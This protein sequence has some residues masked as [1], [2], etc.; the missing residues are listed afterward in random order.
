VKEFRGVFDFVIASR[1]LAKQFRFSIRRLPQCADGY[2]GTHCNDRRKNNLSVTVLCCAFLLLASCSGIEPIHR[3]P[4][5]VAEMK[6]DFSLDPEIRV[7][8]NRP[9]FPDSGK[10]TM[11]ILYA[12]P[13]GNSIEM[14]IGKQ[15]H[16]GDDWHYDI[17]HIGAQVR[18]LRKQLP[19][20]NIVVFYLE[21]KQ[22]SWPAW[23]KMYSNNHEI[24]RTI[25]TSFTTLYHPD[26]E[27]IIAGH[28]G[29]G[30]FINGLLNA[31]DTIPQKIS[32]IAYL[33]ANYSYDDSLDHGK[34]LFQWLY[35]DT[36]HKLSVIAY[37]DREITFNGKKVIS[38]TGGTYRATQRMMNYFR[39]WTDIRSFQDSAILQYESFNNRS[40]F[41][42]HTNP[43]TLILHTVLVEKNGLI[44]SVLFNTPMEEQQY[45]FFGPRAYQEF[46]SEEE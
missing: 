24:I 22:K 41:I 34:K 16:E 38:P 39:E 29:G 45:K 20:V 4:N 27:F 25:V 19:E 23:R 12:L 31:Y 37:D 6:Y 17:Q 36:T 42:V 18:F 2:V 44:H 33:D 1:S 43:D 3:T 5:P 40:R 9:S 46:I 28:S 21:N 26:T 11:V 30:S 15:L 13:N 7:H 10:K 32:R 35:A 8:V 14:T